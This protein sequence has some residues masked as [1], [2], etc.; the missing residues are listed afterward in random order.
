LYIVKSEAGYM[1]Q[2]LSAH[3]FDVADRLDAFFANNEGP[4]HGVQNSAGSGYTPFKK[5][6][7]FEAPIYLT[8]L[9]W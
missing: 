1:A 3:L 9:D 6:D 8:P 7:S 4:K 2:T 5:T